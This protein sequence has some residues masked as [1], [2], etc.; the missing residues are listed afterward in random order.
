[1]L[2]FTKVYTSASSISCVVLQISHEPL[3]EQIEILDAFAEL[4]DVHN[5]SGK[6]HP[7]ALC[8]VLFT[9]AVTAGN[10]GFLAIA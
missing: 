4:P 8:L 1:M 3:T 2:H 5:A 9:L 7:I 10:R 6:R